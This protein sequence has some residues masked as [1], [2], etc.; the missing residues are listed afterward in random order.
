MKNIFSI[1]QAFSKCISS[2]FQSNIRMIQ[3]IDIG[4]THRFVRIPNKK[5]ST[6]GAYDYAAGGYLV[7]SDAQ[8]KLW[9]G[10]LT[11][12]NQQILNDAGFVF[13]YEIDAG[14]FFMEVP[15]SIKLIL[16]DIPS[17]EQ[18]Q[19]L[20]QE[21]GGQAILVKNFLKDHQGDI[22]HLY[23]VP[24]KSKLVALKVYLL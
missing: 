16:K 3:D 4:G 5:H 14:S 22:R 7:V 1:F 2:F 23:K 10:F 21:E 20:Q 8:G 17:S 15:N 9:A 11:L 6:C 18:W 19:K 24:R 12:E 13:D